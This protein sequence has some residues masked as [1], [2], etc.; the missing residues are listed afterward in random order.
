YF[1]DD[2]LG[3]G[4]ANNQIKMLKGEF[5]HGLGYKGEGIYIAVMDL[6]FREIDV[7]PQYEH[8]RSTGR[9]VQGPDFVHRDGSVYNGGGN[10]GTLVMSCMAP[11]ANGEFIG[12]APEATYFLFVTENDTSEYVV[13]EDYWIAAAEWADSAG[14]DVFNTSLG[15]TVFNDSLQNHTYAD[16]DGNT[17]RITKGVDMAAKKGILSVNSAGNS[18]TGAWYYIGAPA[19]CDSC[20]SV[21]A[22]RYNGSYAPFSSKGPSFD[23]RVKPNVV[24]QGDSTWLVWPGNVIAD[25]NGTSFSGPVMAGMVA[26]LWQA[27]P[28]KSNMEIIKAIES[29]ASQHDSPDNFIGYGI[30]NMVRAYEYLAAKNM[31]IDNIHVMLLN[32]PFFNSFGIMF[33]PEE[34]ADVTIRLFDVQGKLVAQKMV[35]LMA[36]VPTEQT[37]DLHDNLLKP[38]VYFVKISMPSGFA[39]F[40]VVKL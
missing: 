36:Q 4:V 5:L 12:T 3:Y 24:A 17:T 34:N 28:Q 15:Y 1:F 2:T 29:T 10:H 35:S 21:G 38:G 6:G 7:L 11:Y 37:L 26:C 19:D 22:V 39:S 8:L 13:E 40:K 33:Y 23:G 14:V 32:N 31:I 9:I 27:F 20:L 30:P 18:G 25:G 16:M